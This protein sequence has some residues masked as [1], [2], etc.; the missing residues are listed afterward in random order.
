MTNDTKHPAWQGRLDVGV[1]R[2]VAEPDDFYYDDAS[3]PD[4]PLCERYHGDGTDP[5]CD[6]LLPCPMCQG[7][8]RP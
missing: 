5:M 2:Q 8:Q 4:D 7:E 1:G 3:E 6:H